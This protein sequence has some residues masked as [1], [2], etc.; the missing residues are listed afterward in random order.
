MKYYIYILL[1]DRYPGN[2]NNNYSEIN[3]KPFYVGKG[4]YNSKNKSERHL[5]HYQ[6]NFCE[7][8]TNP[9]KC[10][11][12]QKLRKENYEP[13]FKIVYED[14]DESKVFEVEKELINFYGRN[15]NGGIL[16]NICVGGVGGDTFTNNPNKEEI[17]EK[18]RKSAIGKNN[19][20][21]GLSLEQS[22]S[23][24]AKI[25]GNH[26]NKGKTMSE[27]HKELLKKLRIERLPII[28]KI[29]KI[30]FNV[31]DELKILDM[32][33]KY[34]LSYQRL[35]FCLNNGGEHK[36]YYWKYKEKELVFKKTLRP[37]YQKPKKHQKSKKVFYKKDIKDV[38]EIEYSNAKEA[39]INLG[40]SIKTIRLKCKKNNDTINVFRYENSEYN[41]D[42]KKSKKVSIIRI[43]DLGNEV[44]FNSATDA[45]KSL[46]NG[47]VSMIIQVCKGNR[48]KHKGFKFKY[49]SK[50]ND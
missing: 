32:V 17:R 30:S 13:N 10:R 39:S 46:N 31:L 11:I 21:Y 9:Q 48:K 43:D 35:F 47:S 28:Q 3:Y 2:Y 42:R 37:D 18:H 24:I 5:I 1:D 16:T 40:M 36:G 44:I 22:P 50:K 15:L 12:I 41:F 29:D 33:E 38:N 4:F 25:N 27:Q 49:L 26:W 45:A 34:G 6:S 19:G 20:M 7:K 8:N 14:N 23:H